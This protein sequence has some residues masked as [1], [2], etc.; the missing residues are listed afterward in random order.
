MQFHYNIPRTPHSSGLLFFKNYYYFLMKCPLHC[1]VKRFIGHQP[2]QTIV[3]TGEFPKPSKE[4]LTARH[5]GKRREEWQ[6]EK[7]TSKSFKG[8][9]SPLGLGTLQNTSVSLFQL[10]Q[11]YSVGDF[12]HFNLRP[13][14]SYL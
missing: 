11:C 1:L 12:G 3:Q 4:T 2:S 8:L 6:G 10:S 9:R 5:H 14:F 13:I 7:D